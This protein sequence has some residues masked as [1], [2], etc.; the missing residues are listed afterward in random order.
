MNRTDSLP[1]LGL[2]GLLLVAVDATPLLGQSPSAV[3]TKGHGLA[4]TADWWNSTSAQGGYLPVH[5]QITNLTPRPRTLRVAVEN[6]Y[7]SKVTA[8]QQVEAPANSSVDVTLSVPV[9][10]ANAYSVLQFYERGR[11]LDNLAFGAVGSASWWGGEAMP[12]VLLVGP[13][14]P[15]VRVFE[16]AARRMAG[17]SGTQGNYQPNIATRDALPTKWI[18]Y[19]MLDLVM[20]PLRELEQMSQPTRDALITWTL[21]GG[22][23]FVFGVSEPREDNSALKRLLDMDNR[24]PA[25]TTWDKPRPEDRE[26]HAPDP[27]GQPMVWRNGR[28]RV[29]ARVNPAG[30]VAPGANA[31]AKAN[32]AQAPAPNFSIRQFGMGQVIASSTADPFPGALADWAWLFNSIGPDSFYWHDRHGVTPRG[33]NHDFWNF[34]IPDVGRAPVG[35][36]QVLITIFAIVIGPVNY[37]VLRRQKRL[38][39]LILTVPAFAALTAVTLLGYAIAS[40]GFG[41]RTR[42]RS[43][44]MLDQKRRE[45]ISWSRA[46]Y[47]AGLAPA[48][49]LRF[50]ADTAVYP[51]DQPARRASDRTLDWTEDQHMTSGW[52]RARTPTQLLVVGYKPTDDHVAVATE[53]GAARVTNQLGTPIRMIVVAG[54]SG[55][56]YAAQDL[57]HGESVR[58]ESQDLSQIHPELRK[59]LAAQVLDLPPEMSDSSE[60]FG[61]FGSSYRYYGGAQ[62]GSEWSTSMLERTLAALRGDAQSLQAVVP[63]GGYVAIVDR[64][65]MVELGVPRSEDAGS[66]Y[67]IVGSY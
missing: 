29:R 51:I 63:P 49:G 20:T 7:P 8:S 4:V 33:Q 66:L 17:G 13:F 32:A 1:L 67:V 12:S 35:A 18:D 5:V 54:R 59:L 30:Q 23:L 6:Q 41:V 56:W 52:L 22:N 11:R 24:P 43:V 25:G 65:T 31:V 26:F 21:A 38:Y 9:I 45:A 2:I 10:N 50:S 61:I 42:V 64:A 3:A 57:A 62:W 36:F 58:V 34:L 53:A 47:Y 48:G 55:E 60:G 19:S 16:D 28:R 46:S 14:A 44:T 27:S 39:L 37:L 15:D 40:D